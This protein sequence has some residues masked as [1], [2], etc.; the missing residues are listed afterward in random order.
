[1]RVFPSLLRFL[2]AS[3]AITTSAFAQ[4]NVSDH[5]GTG[6]PGFIDGPL[7][8]CELHSPFGLCRDAAGNLYFADAGNHCIRKITRD[9]VI[10][11]AGTGTAGNRDTLAA[12]AQFNSPA[13]VAVDDSGNVFVA[14]FQN[15]SIRKIGADGWVTTVAGTGAQGY[16]DGPASTAT[17]RYPRGIAVDGSGNLFVGDSW[18][19]RIRK[20]SGGVVTTFAGSGT[21][22]G[23]GSIGAWIDGPPDS[24]QFYT[25]CG[26]SLDDS[27]NLYVADAY[28]HRIRKIAPDGTVS[29][30]AG[31]G[32]SGASAGGF[33]DGDGATAEL[34]TP[35]ECF[36]HSGS[37]AV[38]FSDT[39]NHAVRRAEQD[40][41][42]TTLAG[43]GF[44][45]FVNGDGT[46]AQFN[47]TRGI[48]ANA[49]GDSVWVCDYNNE[50]VR[51]L[52]GDLLAGSTAPA[53]AGFA[54]YPQPAAAEV[55]VTWQQ[56]GCRTW[57]LRTVTG[58][59]VKGGVACEGHLAI[60]VGDLPA[61]VYVLRMH[62]DP[63]ASSQRV[64]I[65]H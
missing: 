39:F 61:G 46:V 22:F 13:G 7:L 19:H 55:Q 45:G 35:T 34:D 64:L 37:D 60:P 10:T 36:W 9:S 33:V 59:Q 18:N 16:D 54:V 12:F 28:N 44:S 2:L 65:A 43:T 42:V 32:A 1:M 6:T 25:P 63:A 52:T 8:S 29:T 30:L 51:L 3:T 14:D 11:L 24:A 31:N 21:V 15:M 41:T 47:I 23:V 26:L 17:F 27:G 40:G 57:E 50:R 53:L 20:I 58:A 5:A 62:A 48:A 56:S 38:F 49:A 4:V